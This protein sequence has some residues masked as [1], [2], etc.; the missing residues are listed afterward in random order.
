MCSGAA[1]LPTNDERNHAAVRGDRSTAV[2][3][4]YR[5]GLR[6]SIGLLRVHVSSPWAEGRMRDVHRLDQ[7]THRSHPSPHDYMTGRPAMPWNQRT[8]ADTFRTVASLCPSLRS[9]RSFTSVGSSFQGIV[10]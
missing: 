8:T 5:S 7:H 6:S 10:R 3:S 4:L 9:G 2:Y 1:E